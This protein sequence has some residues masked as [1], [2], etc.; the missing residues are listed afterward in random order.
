MNKK[1]QIK[2]RR[3]KDEALVL[4][5]RLAQ[6]KLNEKTA[7]RTMTDLKYLSS[8]LHERTTFETQEYQARRSLLMVELNKMVNK[9]EQLWI[10]AKEDLDELLTEITEKAS[11]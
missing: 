1:Q 10:G 5:Q 4:R 9:A 8:K 6:K 3:I 2:T 11:Q 7:K